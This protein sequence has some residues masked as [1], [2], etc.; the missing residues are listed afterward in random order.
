[1]KALLVEAARGQKALKD[2]L[3]QSARLLTPFKIERTRRNHSGRE[4]WEDPNELYP[5]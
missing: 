3:S 5:H 2:A 1:M 4:P